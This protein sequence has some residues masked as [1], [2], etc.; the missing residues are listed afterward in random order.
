MHSHKFDGNSGV[1]NDQAI[2]M[3]NSPN[4]AKDRQAKPGITL[5]NDLRDTIP[6]MSTDEFVDWLIAHSLSIVLTLLRVRFDPDRF[7]LRMRDQSTLSL[8][9]S[10]DG[11]IAQVVQGDNPVD[12][13]RDTGPFELHTDGAY[14]DVPPERVF[15]ACDREGGSGVQTVFADTQAAIETLTPQEFN[16]LRS[17]E[18]I[19]IDKKTNKYVHPLLERKVEN[20]AFV[21]NITARGALQPVVNGVTVAELPS[22]FQYIPAVNGFLDQLKSATFYRHTWRQNDLVVFDNHR[23]LHGRESIGVDFVRRLWRVWLRQGG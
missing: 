23:L 8:L 7:L 9:S 15:L 17:L 6:E 12:K 5:V 13:S 18:Y 16:I 22:L 1:Q 19:Y 10:T 14:Y 4:K 21:T 2:H 3:D 20:G 11:F